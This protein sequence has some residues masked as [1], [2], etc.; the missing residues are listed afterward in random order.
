METPDDAERLMEV[1]ALGMEMIALTANRVLGPRWKTS[2]RC[3]E[4]LTAAAVVARATGMAVAVVEE[5]P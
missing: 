3:G 4:D 5:E 1:E 2:W